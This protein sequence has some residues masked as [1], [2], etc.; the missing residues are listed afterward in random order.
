MTVDEQAIAFACDGESLIGISST[1]A[2]SGA[3]G[4]VVIVGGPQYRV[5]SHRQFVLLAR[6]LAARGIPTFRFDYRGM[7]DSGG[8]MRAFDTVDADV[9]AAIDAFQAR[10][11]DVR[12]IV[13]WGLCDGASASL[14]YSV[15]DPRVKGLVLLN[16][17]VRNAQSQAVAQIKHYYAR[18]LFSRDLW[19][20]V[21][22]GGFQMGRFLADARRTVSAATARTDRDGG[23]AAPS[24]F[25][26][27]MLRA[28]D[29][30]R[31]PTLVILSGRDL[32]AK[33][34]LE[35][36]NARPDWR[37]RLA[38]DRVTRQDFPDADHTFS[39]ARD[40]DAVADCTAAWI[41]REFPD[42]AVGRNRPDAADGRARV[43]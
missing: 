29:R 1:A 36:A 38:G 28:W 23:G 18:R 30:F 15:R 35:Y 40:R 19:R 9:G 41:H 22:R 12:D 24:A 34:F 43:A 11:P 27:R 5:G 21:L 6:S 33:E 3:V 26:V 17:W 13:L 16:P 39:T 32:T 20:K 42:A 10:H 2:G 4:V 7:G 14:M 37:K 31:G 25:Q 8:D